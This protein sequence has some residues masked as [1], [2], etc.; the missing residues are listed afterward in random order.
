MWVLLKYYLMGFCTKLLL[1]RKP[2]PTETSTL[3]FAGMQ[4]NLNFFSLPDST[5]SG[6]DEEGECSLS[7]SKECP[8]VFCPETGKLSKLELPSPFKSWPQVQV[9]AN[10]VPSHVS[11]RDLYM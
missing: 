2:P 3:S 1:V 7:K 4:R 8:F 11:F 6:V 9:I 5:S 10:Y